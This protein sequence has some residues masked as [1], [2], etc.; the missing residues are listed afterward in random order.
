M[1]ETRGIALIKFSKLETHS[2]LANKALKYLK[3][4]CIG[5]TVEDVVS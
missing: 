1:R 3:F 2:R 4:K 5:G